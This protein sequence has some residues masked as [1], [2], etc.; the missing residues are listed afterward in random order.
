MKKIFI[1]SAA[2]AALLSVSPIN[3]N[4]QN[5]TP[6]TEVNVPKTDTFQII[7]D[8]TEGGVRHIKAVPSKKVCSALMEFDIKKGRIYN[9]VISR[10]C[11]GNLQAIGRLLEGMEVKKAIKTLDGIDCAGRGTSCTDQLAQILKTL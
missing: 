9:L 1:L 5:Q 6:R 3:V 4:A 10:G 7:S 8:T 2:V 11:P